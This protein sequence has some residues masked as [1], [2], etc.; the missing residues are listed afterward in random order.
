MVYFSIIAL[1]VI[2]KINLPVNEQETIIY[3]RVSG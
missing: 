1:L 3:V 2:Q